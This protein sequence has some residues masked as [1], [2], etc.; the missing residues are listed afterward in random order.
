MRLIQAASPETTVGQSITYYC[1]KPSGLDAYKVVAPIASVRVVDGDSGHFRVVKFNLGNKGDLMVPFV[2]NFIKDL[3]NDKVA[4]LFLSGAHATIYIAHYEVIVHEGMSIWMAIV[5]IIIIVVVAYF[6]WGS[7]GGALADA[8]ITVAMQTATQVVINA[9]INYLFTY[10]VNM[11]VKMAVQYLVQLIIVE[12]AGDDSELAMMLSLISMV[13]IS[14]WDPGITVGSGVNVG[15][16]QPGSYGKAGG[17]KIGPG[18]PGSS[19]EFANSPGI[20]MNMSFRNF[21]SL[22]AM[23]F[24][25]IGLAAIT[26]FNEFLA[27]K[28]ETLAEELA[29]DKVQFE[30]KKREGDELLDSARNML[31]TSDIDPLT[32][33][34]ATRARSPYGGMGPGIY[35]LCNNMSGVVYEMPYMLNE[36]RQQDIGVEH[37]F[38][39]A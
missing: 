36:K 17:I 28:T 39:F 6:T 20:T 12:I 1:C 7:D 4:R 26:G 19:I 3:S 2:H 16:V 9:A 34:A 22:T 30:R 8:I 37:H 38:M 32:I 33:L 25:K 18:T 27:I 23:D 15:Q 14:M 31:F 10:I 5:L 24:A 13:A 29:K 35:E 21:S 11:V